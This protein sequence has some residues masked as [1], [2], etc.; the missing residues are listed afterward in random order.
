MSEHS[1]SL[2]DHAVHVSADRTRR[3][4]QPA[5]KFTE[6]DKKKF[7]Q[8]ND[9][10]RKSARHFSSFPVS[11]VRAYNDKGRAKICMADPKTKVADQKAMCVVSLAP[12][13][14]RL[15]SDLVKEGNTGKGDNPTKRGDA[16]RSLGLVFGQPD[17]SVPIN[18]KLKKEQDDCAEKLR[19]I[20]R[21]AL[22]AVFDTTA[23]ELAPAAVAAAENSARMKIQQQDKLES[24]EDVKE[25]ELAED[26]KMAARVKEIARTEFMANGKIPFVAYTDP[27]TKKKKE[28]MAW[29]ESKVYTLEVDNNQPISQDR[30]KG[31]PLTLIP[32]SIE[33][34]PRIYKLM[35]AINYTP[36]K[37]VYEV[38]DKKT[39]KMVQLQHP[40]V[41]VPDLDEMGNKIIGP[42]GQPI[43]VP[44]P[45]L[46][47]NPLFEGKDGTKLS[48]L[49]Q[50]DVLV[51]FT[52]GG[53][54]GNYGIKL[55]LYGAI[56]ITH[57]APRTEEEKYEYDEDDD[58]NQGLW[59][60][61][62]DDDADDADADEKAAKVADGST[63]STT[64]VVG[65]PGVGA[66]TTHNT[67]GDED[68]DDVPPEERQNKRTKT[69]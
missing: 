65:L 46:D 3:R 30:E 45:S 62:N 28:A 39:H 61:D 17:K 15:G 1:S 40:L 58:F 67:N 14:A 8:M 6:E 38:R 21:A 29:G 2:V 48:S 60:A 63:F 33:N 16:K 7:K 37:V 68:D 26:G 51:S 50:V 25:L 22:G 19:Q 11:D 55:V 59:G 13:E 32:T 10:R 49:V 24:I 53:K 27:K 31:P 34:M 69:Q 35:K 54:K 9:E 43:M 23:R 52:D 56:K 42:N 47:W 41:M 20:C 44:V 57:Q 4:K 64:S 36:K 5:H 12:F 18:P 66:Q